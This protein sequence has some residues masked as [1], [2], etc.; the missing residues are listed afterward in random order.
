V[1]DQDTYAPHVVTAEDKRRWDLWVQ[2][3]DAL[4]IDLDD[5]ERRAGAPRALSTRRTSRP[6][7]SQPAKRGG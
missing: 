2:D 4:F 7:P 6:A 3:A 5:G 1:S